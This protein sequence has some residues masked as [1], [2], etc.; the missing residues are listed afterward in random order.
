[1]T[2]AAYTADAMRCELVQKIDGNHLDQTGHVENLRKDLTARIEGLSDKLDNLRGE[3][4]AVRE[5]ISSAKVWAMLLYAALA[6]SMCLVMAHGF[7]W[8]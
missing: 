3:L 6:G 8:I 1:V 2:H 4:S 5:S 7:H